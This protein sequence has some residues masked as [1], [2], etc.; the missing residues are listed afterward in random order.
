MSV[1]ETDLWGLQ[2]RSIPVQSPW[3]VFCV[4]HYN[5]QSTFNMIIYL[6]HRATWMVAIE[7]GACLVVYC[8]HFDHYCS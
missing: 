5:R 4:D 8:N 1:Y 3:R 6:D 7:V 2:R